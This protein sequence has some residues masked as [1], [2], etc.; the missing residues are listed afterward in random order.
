[1]NTRP[2]REQLRSLV[3]VLCLLMVVTSGATLAG[4]RAEHGIIDELA[5]VLGPARDQNRFLL[6]NATDAQSAVRGYLATHDPTFLE[7]YTGAEQRGRTAERELRTLLA[8]TGISADNRRDYA[9]QQV[10]QDTAFA[11]WWRFIDGAVAMTRQ[12]RHVDLAIS[13]ALFDKASA[14]NTRLGTGMTQLRLALRA[15]TTDVL[16]IV[17]CFVAFISAFTVVTTIF[18]ARRISR[19]LTV[20][21]TE[22]QHVVRLQ[23]DGDTVVRADEAHGAVEVRDLAG[24]FNV[25]TDRNN[26]LV[27]AQADALRLQE[28]ALDVETALRRASGVDETVQML[29]ST[30]GPALNARRVLVDT[31]YHSGKIIRSGQWHSP[32]LDDLP[33]ISDELSVHLSRSLDHLWHTSGRLLL[34]DLTAC[35]DSDQQWISLFRRETGAESLLMVPVGLG[36]RVIGTIKVLYDEPR[37][38]SSTEATTVQQIA[39]FLARAITQ[40]ESE[41]QQADYVVRLEQL[42]TQKTDFLSTVSHELRTPLTSIIGYVELLMDGAG[43]D[44]NADQERMLVVIERNTIRLRGLIEDLLV[45][46]RI[47]SGG[48]SLVTTAVSFPELIVQTVE[49][50]RPISDRT[51]VQV[52]VDIADDGATVV[53]DPAYLQRILVNVV[54]NA[55]KFTSTEGSVRISCAIDPD[56]DHVTVTCQDTGIGIPEGDMEHLFNRF[57][58]ASNA[59]AHAIP[60]T[61]LGLAIVRTITELHHGQLAL[62]SIEGV[63]TTVTLRFPSAGG[64]AGRPRACPVGG[65]DH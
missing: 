37:D 17:I 33:E 34:G 11:A 28:V 25:L 49:E 21:I 36:A 27:R 54:S 22:L 64:T 50:L 53:G 4:L 35:D 30:L 26:E 9:R 39:A 52:T 31:L 63:G 51:D 38:W 56:T 59:T 15:D 6:E 2:V 42:D 60:G 10:E 16:D 24:V 41:A 12:G 19:S 18:L 5:N 29:C 48:L 32:D 55:I 43:G 62:E 46:N 3:V 61:G 47:E 1:M 40:A 45:L 57:F 8:N 23:R 14:N 20:P 44:V 13:R 65:A 58:R 7:A